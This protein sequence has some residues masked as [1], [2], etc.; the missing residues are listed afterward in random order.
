MKTVTETKRRLSEWRAHARAYAAKKAL[1]NTDMRISVNDLYEGIVAK[2]L[3][4]PPMVEV[5]KRGHALCAVF[6][7]SRLFIDTGDTVLSTNPTSR[8]RKVVVWEYA[9]W[10]ADD[11]GDVCIRSGNW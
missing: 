1:E 6:S 3:Q 4:P 7:G 11:D 5:Y 8:S 2:E 9:P 10:E